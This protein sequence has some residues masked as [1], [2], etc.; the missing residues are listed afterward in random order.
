MIG[1]YV[2]ESSDMKGKDASAKRIDWGF[3]W[4]TAWKV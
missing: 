2:N 3:E 4:K 1:H